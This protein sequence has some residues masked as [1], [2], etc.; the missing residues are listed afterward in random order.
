MKVLVYIINSKFKSEISKE[1]ENGTL[2]NRQLEIIEDVEYSKNVISIDIEDS[3]IETLRND[4]RIDFCIKSSESSGNQR[5]SSLNI[6]PENRKYI[7][8]NSTI[9]LMNGCYLF[10]HNYNNLP[11][12]SNGVF[13]IFNLYDT[14]R[15]AFN[16]INNEGLV[17]YVNLDNGETPPTTNWR[18]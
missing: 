3:E 1:L 7:V 14:W 2:L 17:V 10:K 16:D 8:S 5:I 13:N 6:I 15:I 18:V 11:L 12:Y 9:D 4:D